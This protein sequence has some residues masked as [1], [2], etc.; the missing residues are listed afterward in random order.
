MKELEFIRRAKLVGFSLDEIRELLDLRARRGAPCKAVRE[1]AVAKREA[2][3]AK[4]AE[5][6][7]LRAA[8]EEL[9]SVCTGSVAVEQCSILGALDG[10]TETAER[11]AVRRAQRG[12]PG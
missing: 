10:V 4:I 7:Q 12:R 3:D 9:V 2:I 5:L 11:K 8:V 1:R 6:S